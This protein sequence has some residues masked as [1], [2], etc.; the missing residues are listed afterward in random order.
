MPQGHRLPIGRYDAAFCRQGVHGSNLRS[1][2]LLHGRYKALVRLGVF[3]INLCNDV[4]KVPKG[5]GVVPAEVLDEGKLLRGVFPEGVAFPKVAALLQLGRGGATVKAA[6]WS[7]NGAMRYPS[8]S[9]A[10]RIRP[11]LWVWRSKFAIRKSTIIVLS[12]SRPPFCTPSFS[13]A[14]RYPRCISR[15]SETA[16]LHSTS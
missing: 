10:S 9:S 16:K 11:K 15:P 4:F 8:S 12:M 5:R 13:S 7:S 2:L 1:G 6:A 14:F 3:A